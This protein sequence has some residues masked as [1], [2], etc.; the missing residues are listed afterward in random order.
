MRR[1][2]LQL[3]LAL[4]ERLEAQY[5]MSFRALTRAERATMPGKLIAVMPKDALDTLPAEIVEELR[6]CRTEIAQALRSREA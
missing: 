2:Q 3:H 6:R 4:I 1:S 5:G